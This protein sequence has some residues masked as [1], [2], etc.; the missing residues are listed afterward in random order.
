M[1]LPPDCASE[2]RLASL[3]TENSI[4]K[5]LRLE[6]PDTLVLSTVMGFR[7][8]H[9]LLYQPGPP[10]VLIVYRPVVTVLSLIPLLYAMALSV[11]VLEIVT[12]LLYSVPVEE[13]G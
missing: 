8:L 11:V 2:A 5:L 7:L 6:P 4:G 13:V 3:A 12:G 10:P 1:S 9:A